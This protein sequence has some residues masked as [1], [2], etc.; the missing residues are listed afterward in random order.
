MH[1]NDGRVVSNF[2]MHALQGKEISIYGDGQQTRS[3]CYVDD[4]V[5]GL[6][7]MMASPKETTGPVNLNPVEFTM[8]G[9]ADLVKEITGSRSPIVHSPLPADDP[10]QRRPDIALARKELSWEP[11]IALKEGLTKTVAYLRICYVGTRR[12]NR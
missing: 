12:R 5:E 11:K 1:P 9:L 2:I 8:L 6:V 10:R 3:F 4:L 7:R